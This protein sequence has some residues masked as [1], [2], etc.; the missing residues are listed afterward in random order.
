MVTVLRKG[1]GIA[2]WLQSC[3]KVAILRN[4]YGLADQLRTCESVAYCGFIYATDF[5]NPQYCGFEKSVADPFLLIG[6]TKGI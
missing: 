6:N 4:D 5:S 2:E 3:E 1:R